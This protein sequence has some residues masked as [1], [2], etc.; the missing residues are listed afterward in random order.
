MTENVKVIS[1]YN[2]KIAAHV[3]KHDAKIQKTFGIISI[4][5]KKSP[6]VSQKYEI[7]GV[8]SIFIL[9][10]HPL[11]VTYRIYAIQQKKEHEQ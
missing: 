2:L 3:Y 4:T 10:H 6:H 1:Q 5:I 11:R 9:S 8:L 7:I